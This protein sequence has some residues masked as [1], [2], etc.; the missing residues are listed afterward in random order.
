[1]KNNI[2]SNSE[3]YNSELNENEILYFLKYVGLIHEIIEIANGSISMQNYDYLKYI[4]IKAITNTNYIYN[5]L[6]LYTKNLE[7][8]VY[9]TQKS[10]LY[11]IEF[12]SQISDDN[13]SSL[14]LNSNDATLFIYKKTIFDVNEEFRN[15]YN[16]CHNTKN[17]LNHI[18]I[19]IKIYN[20]IIL[21]YIDNLEH[22]DGFLHGL[23]EI[24]YTKLYKIVESLIQLNL[25][26]SQVTDKLDNLIIIID[27]LNNNYNKSFVKNNYLLIIEFII[28]KIKKNSI[29]VDI[30]KQ[31]IYNDQTDEYIKD[32][33]ICKIVN[34]LTS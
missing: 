28:K 10:I 21:Q 27:L 23:Q 31:K 8:V 17:K 16:E 5:F 9:H 25:K 24:V 12:I 18:N 3:N 7:L 13:H 1:M 20:S 15:K 29:N 22:S 32:Y 33:T 19:Y 14:K 26:D 11:Y 30:F 34:Y 6:L 4:L 2:L